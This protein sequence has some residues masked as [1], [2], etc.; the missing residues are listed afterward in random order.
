MR[1][2]LSHNIVPLLA[3]LFLISGCESKDQKAST[4]AAQADAEFQQGRFL[5][6]R[7]AVRQ[8]IAARDDVSDYWLL[9]ARIDMSLKDYSGAFD[10]YQNVL[11]FDRSNIEALRQLSQLALTVRAPDKVDKFADQLLLLNPQDPQPLI[12]KGGAALQRNDAAT[13]LKFAEQVL[14]ANPTDV[15][16]M[17]LKGQVLAFRQDYKGAAAL[18]EASLGPSGDQTSKLTFLRNLYPRTGNLDGYARAVRRLAQLNPGD[19]AMQLALADLLYQTEHPAEALALLRRIMLRH[20]ADI[21]LASA[22]VELWLEQGA[23][24]LSAAQIADAQSMPL[25]MKAAFAQFAAETG[26]ADLTTKMLGSAIA[27]GEPTPANSDAKAAYAFG[28]GLSGS[29]R[30]GLAQLDAILSVDPRQPR[31]LLARARLR[32][33]MGNAGG[34]LSDARQVVADDPGNMTARIALT[35]ILLQKQEAVLAMGNL[36]EAIRARPETVRPVAR[37]AEILSRSGRRD[38]LVALLQDLIRNAPLNLRARRLLRQYGVS[39]PAAAAA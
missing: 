9:L 32:G 26:R 29:G 34:A 1:S 35:D 6:A 19:S 12:A 39:P 3:A 13:A 27:L 36:R 21:G 31:A 37:L 14:S 4:A 28:V 18:I 30:E 22:I 15:G 10:A 8:A 11:Q 23:N 24:A 38:E 17:I 25:E 7:R 16:A 2:H 20:P 33:L 5:P